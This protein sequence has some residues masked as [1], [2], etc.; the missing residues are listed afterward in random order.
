MG[1]RAN[2]YLAETQNINLSRGGRIMAEKVSWLTDMDKALEQAK[3]TNK[4]V[5]L[6][7]FN[8]N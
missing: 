8:P 7:F 6:D 1:Q 4:P 3:K 2:I 5:L